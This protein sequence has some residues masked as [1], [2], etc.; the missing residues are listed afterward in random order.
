M[1]EKK[2]RTCKECDRVYKVAEFQH[3]Q[4]GQRI[5]YVCIG[6]VDVVLARKEMRHRLRSMIH[7]RKKAE[8]KK[9]MRV[10]GFGFVPEV[11][12]L[13]LLIHDQAKPHA[14]RTTRKF[15][16]AR[17][18]AREWLAANTLDGGHCQLY[19]I[20][21]TTADVKFIPAPEWLD[22]LQ[23]YDEQI[24]ARREAV[25]NIEG[26]RIIPRNPR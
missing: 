19:K 8:R 26:V 12:W 20:T 25:A 4:L 17:W 16:T 22:H 14:R 9:E 21:L 6:C 13:G 23:S 24:K 15:F 7:E 18:R 10:P 11:V 3:G 2:L 1:P 5:G